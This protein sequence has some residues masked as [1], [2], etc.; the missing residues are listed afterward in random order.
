[1]VVYASLSKQGPGVKF[2]ERLEAIAL[3][4]PQYCEAYICRGVVWGL[5][6]KQQKGLTELEQALHLNTY[7]E[8][9]WF[10]KGMMC[11]Y[12]GR[13][14]V[15]MEFI[16]RALQIGLPPMLLTPLFWLEQDHLHF[17]Q[18]YAEPLLKRYGLL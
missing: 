1:M 8:D 11:A 7:Q 3:L 10:W 12:L 4:D 18:E 16:E 15:A 17:Y 14:T 2:A 5:C 9:A 13:S 6:G